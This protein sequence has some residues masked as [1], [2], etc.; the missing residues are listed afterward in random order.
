[1]LKTFLLFFLLS[2]SFSLF[3]KDGLSVLGLASVKVVNPI[4]L[5][6]VSVEGTSSLQL[7]AR[8][9]LPVLINIAEIS[10]PSS[11]ERNFFSLS[12]P[13]DVVQI[14]DINANHVLSLNIVSNYDM[15]NIKDSFFI[16]AEW[17]QDKTLSQSSNVPV[18]LAGSFN[19]SIDF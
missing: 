7:S 1:M 6:V 10:L 8:S 17:L 3:A 4:S 19:V 11:I 14:K 2:A 5:P 16:S 18:F 9:L 13:T 12:L 15:T